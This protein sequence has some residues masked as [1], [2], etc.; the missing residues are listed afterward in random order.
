M[1]LQLYSQLGRS[2]KVLG[3]IKTYIQ[4][5]M[6]MMMMKMHC[7][8]SLRFGAKPRHLPYLYIYIF[9]FDNRIIPH[10]QMMFLGISASNR[11]CTPFKAEEAQEAAGDEAGNK[12]LCSH[13]ATENLQPPLSI[14]I[15]EGIFAGH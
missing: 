2:T 7:P 8:S 6:M 13:K 5:M 12:R 10:V 14:Y 4:L 15:Y 11:L 1:L 9:V 3:N